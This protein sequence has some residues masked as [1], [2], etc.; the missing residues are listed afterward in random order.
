V[1]PEEAKVFGDRIFVLGR[2]GND[3]TVFYVNLIYFNHMGVKKKFSLE[4]ALFVLSM[5]L[6]GQ[7]L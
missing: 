1:P 6:H 5:L 7:E 3:E 4:A 2:W